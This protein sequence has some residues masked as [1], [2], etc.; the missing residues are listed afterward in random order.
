MGRVVRGM[1][2][3]P[4]PASKPP[5][6]ALQ[7]AV[8]RTVAFVNGR[9]ADYYASTEPWLPPRFGRREWGFMFLAKHFVARHIAF[10]E[11]EELKRYL[12]S[13]APAHAYYSTAY[14]ENAAAPT[15]HEKGWLGAD[16]IFDL[17]ADHVLGAQGK[18]F[19]EMLALVKEETQWLIDEFLE[20]DFGFSE[21]EMRIVFSGGRGYH[22]HVT[23]P[24][25][26]E[27]GSP[28][29]RDIVDYVTATGLVPEAFVHERG[30]DVDAFRGK[31]K[32]TVVM[33]APDAPGWGGRLAR[34]VLRKVGELRSMPEEQ[35][36]AALREVKGV[37]EKR[38]RDTLDAIRK[39]QAAHGANPAPVLPRALFDAWKKAAAV[40]AAGEADEPVTSDIKRLIR[41][42]GS[43]HGKT[44]LRVTILRRDELEGFDPLRDA[45]PWSEEP[46][47]VKVG[48]PDAFTIRGQEFRV[49]PGERELPLYAA[50]FLMLRRKALAA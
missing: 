48:Q 33:P 21:K 22:V 27:L 19:H 12:A 30:Y 3:P 20:R 17:D 38:A 26:L 39:S 47:R 6:P 4:L 29:R 16:L 37:G 35:A 40:E 1:A 43:I 7:A 8:E 44:G 10:R 15:M 24:E 18:P 34:V 28:E 46:V 32:K 25:V 45:V 50:M 42:P 41:L 49:A 13:Q 31:A 2:T 9:L 36:L 11:K 5:D 23:S 14:Y